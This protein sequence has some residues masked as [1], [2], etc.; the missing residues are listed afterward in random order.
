MEKYANI[1]IQLKLSP[2]EVHKP[3]LQCLADKYNG[4]LFK[5]Y[6]I[7]EILDIIQSKG[8]KILN[9]G[10]ILF[11]IIA[12]CKVLDPEIGVT[13]N[14]KITNINKMGALHK[15]NLL[16][17][18]IPT[19]YYNDVSPAIDGNYNITIIGKRIEDSIVCVGKI[20]TV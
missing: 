4:Q 11:K 12:H 18:F 3:L 6:Y 1:H 5:K 2:D 20:A 7:F 8:G 16:T 19:Q 9:N 13:Y 14:L 10:K 15:D 17:I